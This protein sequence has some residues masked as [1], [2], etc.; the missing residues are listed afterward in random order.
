MGKTSDL[1]VVGMSVR[2]PG[3]TDAETYWQNL[4]SGLSSIRRLSDEELTAAG[5]PESRFNRP[6][7]VP[8]AAPLD[9]FA[10]FDAEFFGLSP[11][12][13]AIMD[14]QHRQFLEVAWEAM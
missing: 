7:Y 2:L 10:E 3:A 11:K 14:P 12:E 4:R 1:A 5:V 8:F 13:A 6:D 9:G